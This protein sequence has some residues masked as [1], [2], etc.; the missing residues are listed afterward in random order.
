MI[1]SGQDIEN[2][3]MAH[4]S[5]LSTAIYSLEVNSTPAVVANVAIVMQMHPQRLCRGRPAHVQMVPSANATSTAAA[6]AAATAA[7]A[8]AIA[9]P[10]LPL[11]DSC[12]ARV[13]LDDAML[14]LPHRG[15]ESS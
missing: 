11:P 1:A 9:D 14:D 5:S 13:T 4:H 15:D 12:G 6:A 10:L 8:A 3:S 2:S 7:S